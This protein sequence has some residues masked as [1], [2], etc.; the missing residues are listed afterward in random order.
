MSFRHPENT[1]KKSV[2]EAAIRLDG[3]RKGGIER[4]N[5]ANTNL[6][7]LSL[8]RDVEQTKGRI[9]LLHKQM[10]VGDRRTQ[11][12]ME[13]SVGYG[14]EGSRKH[15]IS[16]LNKKYGRN[17]QWAYCAIMNMSAN[18][19]ERAHVR[20]AVSFLLKKGPSDTPD[21]YKDKL[22]DAVDDVMNEAKGMRNQE[23]L[24]DQRAHDD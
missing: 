9:S 11:F 17:G 7:F 2:S 10:A 23:V 24:H 4:V 12:G 22:S 3:N 16:V 21:Q 14:R 13:G 5:A 1:H 15:V 19:V 18:Q 8:E 6:R 20:M